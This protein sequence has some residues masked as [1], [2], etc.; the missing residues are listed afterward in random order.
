MRGKVF[1]LQN[2]AI[3]IALSLPL[4]LAGLAESA[5]GLPAVFVGLGVLASGLGVLTRW[6]DRS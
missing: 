5:W 1:G 3:N 4:S 2:N 6:L